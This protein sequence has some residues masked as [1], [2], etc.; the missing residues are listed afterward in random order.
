LIQLALVDDHQMFREGLK[1]ILSDTKQYNVVL[2]CEN[3]REFMTS[4]DSAID[5]ILMDLDM[6]LMNGLQTMEALYQ[7]DKEAKIVFISQNREAK[8]IS[9][10]ME[11]GARGYLV[12]DATTEE[13]KAAI[14]SVHETGFYFN[15]IV[16]Q[17]LLVKLARKEQIQPRFNQGE[18]LS[19]REW[20][21]LKLICEEMTTKEIGEKLFL[22]PKTVENHRTRIMSKT[23]VRNSAGLV[24]Y[25]IKNKL[26]DVG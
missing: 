1:A 6:P 16:S 23:G 12:K 5:V 7:I 13:L 26:I 25:A 18:Q 8:S 10:L 9:R 14:H 15:D 21:V 3:G 19:N 4:Y 24:I 22:S 2:E 11:L 17:S 20:E